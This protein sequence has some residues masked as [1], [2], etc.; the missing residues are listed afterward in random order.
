MYD[1]NSYSRLFIDK[2]RYRLELEGQ[3]QVMFNRPSECKKLYS[4]SNSE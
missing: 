1:N 4:N 2:N 3:E